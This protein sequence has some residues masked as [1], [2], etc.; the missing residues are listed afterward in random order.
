LFVLNVDTKTVLLLHEN[1]DEKA[2]NIEVKSN[3]SKD[4][5]EQVE[6]LVTI[7]DGEMWCPRKECLVI[8]FFEQ[9]TTS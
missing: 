5:I 6:K 9:K 2:F 7:K 3:A 1:Q 8:R 4:V